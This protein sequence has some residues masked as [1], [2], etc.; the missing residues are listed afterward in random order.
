MPIEPRPSEALPG[1]ATAF[2]EEEMRD[3][4]Q[5]A[6]FGTDGSDYVVERCTPT[7]PLYMPG[8]SCLLRYQFEASNRTSGEIL[9]PIVTGRVFRNRSTCAAYMRDKLAPLVARMRSRPEVA[10]F[11]A[12]AAMIEPLNMVVHVWPIDGDLPTLVDA[13]DRE[14]MV[15]IFRQTLPE[16][17][18]QPFVVEDCQIEL[19][20]YRRRQRCV[21]R[22]TV[23]GKQAG[24]E[25]PRRLVAFGKVSAV[26]NETPKD[27]IIGALRRRIL[28]RGAGRGFS[29]PQ[30]LGWRPDL[31][32]S[33]LEALPGEAQIG[34]ALKARLLGERAP[35]TLSLEEMVAACGHAA[36]ALHGSGVT[37]GA[38]RTLDDDLSGLLREMAIVQ[39]FVRNFGDRA[40]AWSEQIAALAEQSEPL[41]PCLSHGDFKY[42]QLLFDGA[43]SALVDFDAVCQAEPALDLGKFLAH[44]RVEARKL[45]QRASPGSALG[46]ELAEQFLRAYVSATADQLEDE[47]QLR[48]RTTLYEAVALLHL[49]LWSQR[50]LDDTRLQVTTGLLEE[51]I[52]SIVP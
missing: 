18:E 35:G 10:A 34:P 36:A 20:S 5:S 24:G 4:L 13:T 21:L 37:L 48:L 25:G 46:E 1:L 6:L 15:E 16:S 17:L 14:R 30:S 29:V 33:L 8:E 52:S 40:R 7:R 26:G 43:R 9:E 47:R 22:Y 31:Q 49:T 11:A 28:E 12:P 42:E 38:A 41:R 32:L 2:D 19:V 27:V 44:L 23:V 51:R 3:H 45:Q 39:P 50:N